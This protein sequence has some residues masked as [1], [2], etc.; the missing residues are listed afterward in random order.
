MR[1]YYLFF[2]KFHFVVHMFTSSA[3]YPLVIE[4]N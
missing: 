2:K 4:K 3:F 1:V